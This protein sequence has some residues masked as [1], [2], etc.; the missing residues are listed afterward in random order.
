M[1]FQRNLENAVA[2]LRFSGPALYRELKPVFAS[3]SQTV[4]VA[5][6]SDMLGERLADFVVQGLIRS[7]FFIELVQLPGVEST[8][9]E[10]R[11]A[12]RLPSTDPRFASFDT[13]MDIFLNAVRELLR[14]APGSTARAVLE[15]FQ[16]YSVLPYEVPLDYRERRRRGSIHAPDNVAWI[17]DDNAV[18]K[19]INLRKAIR[20]RSLVGDEIATFRAAL[21]KTKVKTYLTDRVLTGLHKTNREKRWEVHP[22]SVHFATRAACLGIEAELTEEICHFDGFPAAVRARLLDAGLIRQR[23]VTRCPVTL[24]PLG[25]EELKAEL[26][27]PSHGKAAFQVGHLNPLKAVN[28]DPNVGHTAKNIAWVSAEGNRIQGSLSLGETRR[29]IRE[30]AERY[31]AVGWS[32][33]S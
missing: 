33:D 5:Q 28:D 14:A 3:A 31:D 21:D 19:T 24:A 23:D 25:Y 32:V 17:F 4:E 27:N 22:G 13:C 15:A 18:Q 29:M 26:L 16:R 30:I 8:K 7:A 10:V 12:E 20:D 9:F 2:Q 6:A 1:P 11:W